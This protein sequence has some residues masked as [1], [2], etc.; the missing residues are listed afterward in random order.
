MHTKYKKKIDMAIDKEVWFAF[1][2]VQ[3][4]GY[5]NMFDPRARA[6]A[7]EVNDMNITKE[8][9]TFVITNYDKLKET[10]E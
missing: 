1:R 5:Y 10:Y 6:L 9:W 4:A 8:Q 2:A 3:D 7:N